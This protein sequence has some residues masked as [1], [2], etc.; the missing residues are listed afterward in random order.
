MAIVTRPTSPNEPDLLKGNEHQALVFTDLDC[1]QLLTIQAPAEGW[2]HDALEKA[3]AEVS[4]EI[5][6]NG[7]DVY[8]NLASPDNWIGSSEV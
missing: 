8:L 7:W 5:L 4:D 1:N 2:T 3:E 6:R